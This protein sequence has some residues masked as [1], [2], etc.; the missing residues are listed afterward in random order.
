MARAG[1][2][3]EGLLAGLISAGG[4]PFA[5]PAYNNAMGHHPNGPT[6]SPLWAS[7]RRHWRR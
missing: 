2:V 7:Y 4:K 3:R 5:V 6:P 1:R